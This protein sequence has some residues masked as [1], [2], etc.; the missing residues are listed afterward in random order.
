MVFSHHDFKYCAE[1]LIRTKCKIGHPLTVVGTEYH[2]YLGVVRSGSWSWNP[3]LDSDGEQLRRA[4]GQPMFQNNI[5]VSLYAK[6]TTREGPTTKLI[7]GPLIFKLLRLAADETTWGSA[8]ELGLKAYEGIKFKWGCVQTAVGE[9]WIV[10]SDASSSAESLGC[11]SE[12]SS[13]PG[14]NS[15]VGSPPRL[16]S[17]PSSGPSTG[18]PPSLQETGDESP[19]GDQGPIGDQDLV[20]YQSPAGDQSPAS[21]SRGD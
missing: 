15:P 17:S 7:Q 9:R 14:E 12:A 10:E 5:T 19:V 16:S 3:V 1:Q 2:G 11:Y 6:C 8:Q 4:D 21:E 20:V 18:G 13:R